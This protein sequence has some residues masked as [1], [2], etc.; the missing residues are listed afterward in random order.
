MALS[1]QLKKG[2]EV[3][4]LAA[5]RR[6]WGMPLL[7]CCCAMVSWCQEPC[8]LLPHDMDPTVHQTP[9]ETA[10]A[11]GVL[12]LR[13][14]DT[15]CALASFTQEIRTNP[16]AWQG[17]YHAGL[18]YLDLSDAHHAVTELQLA[19]G[20]APARAEIRLALGIAQEALGE[21]G[22]AEGSYRTAYAMDPKSPE[23]TRHLA[24]VLGKEQQ[25]GAAINYWR[26][27]LTLAPYDFDLE[28]SL[29]TAL[30]DD[31]QNK[32]AAALLN[33]MVQQKPNSGLALLNL[34]AVL[35]RE[36]EYSDSAEAYRRASQL[37]VVSEPAKFSLAK[38]LITLVRFTEARPL[39][40]PYVRDHPESMEAHYL[41]GITYQ[42]IGNLEQAKSELERAV[43][44][45][46]S[47]FDSQYKLG[48]VLREGGEYDEAILHLK[49]AVA[50]K[51]ESQ[52]A[53][54]QL[55]RAYHQA[56]QPELAEQENLTFQR[57]QKAV[58]DQ[59]RAT[60]LENDGARDVKD[61]DLQKAV[62]AYKEALELVPEDA[63]VR[64]DLALVFEKLKDREAERAL[65][66]QAVALNPSI[67]DVHNQLGFLDLT[68]GDAT[69]AE[70]EFQAA[71]RI[72]PGM[73]DAL[74]NLGV[75]YGQQGKLSAAERLL[76]LAV[77]SDSSYEKGHMNLGLILAAEGRFQEAHA[78]MKKALALSATDA[79]AL[80]AMSAIEIRLAKPSN[81]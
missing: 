72:D 19:A 39:L 66:L 18:A 26:E 65:L 64:Y 2:S 59:R 70:H 44:L 22:Q 23:I 30:M 43:Q 58:V 62:S 12:F 63:K 71:L 46:E 9:G 29:A 13:D 55:D 51:P 50:L 80:H 6:S 15:R 52:E 4:G 40:E 77:E 76:R 34:G 61:G 37:D 35:Y 41:L 78:Q 20:E 33:E 8:T 36:Q 5:T 3:Y 56:K 16:E 10:D 1:E 42:G 17:H 74:G 31:G 14:K 54:F 67:A 28:L 47:D 45:N 24:V 75:L 48:S 81:P 25:R 79:V 27:A 32:A 21:N 68:N 11:Q 38:V 57:L 73:T 53:H 69:G 49:R 60:V 7:V